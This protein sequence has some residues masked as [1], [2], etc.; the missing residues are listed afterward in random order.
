MYQPRHS[1]SVPLSRA[2]T[3][4]W[5]TVAFSWAAFRFVIR[6]FHP[7]WY[8]AAADGGAVTVA[9]VAIA[10]RYAWRVSH[11]RIAD[12][13][14]AALELGEE[15]SERISCYEQSL[16]ILN[17]RGRPDLLLVNSGSGPGETSADILPLVPRSSAAAVPAGSS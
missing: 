5:V 15:N 11:Q 17:R 10:G 14:K 9:V 6:A 3:V 13:A 1:E 7:G 12:A 4:A 8:G 16:R 2:R